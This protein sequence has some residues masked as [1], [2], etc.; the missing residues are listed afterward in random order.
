[1]QESSR[2]R[3]RREEANRDAEAGDAEAEEDA[4]AQLNLDADITPEEM[5]MMQAMGIPFVSP[6]CSCLESAGHSR[7][8]RFVIIQQQWQSSLSPH[9]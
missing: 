2:K 5:Q 9:M 4:A 6:S 3:A 7:T 8:C 1:M